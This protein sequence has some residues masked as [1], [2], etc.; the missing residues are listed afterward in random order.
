MYFVLLIAPVLIIIVAPFIL[1]NIYSRRLTKLLLSGDFAGFDKVIDSRICKMVIYPFN[2]EYMKL[3]KALM[4]GDEK[5][6]DAAFAVFDTRK[7]NDKQKQAVY[8]NGFYYYVSKEDKGK[9]RKYRDALLEMEDLP[10]EVKKEIND[11]YDIN[12]NGSYELL[13]ITLDKLSKTTNPEEK[14]KYLIMIAKMYSN[15]GDD[16][17]AKEYM[18]MLMEKTGQV[19]NKTTS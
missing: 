1:R 19:S 14:V 5:D 7:L 4:I 16:A 9:S 13:D 3:N 15:K 6:I 11:S 10:K 8:Y 18:D 12:I 2:I 17:K